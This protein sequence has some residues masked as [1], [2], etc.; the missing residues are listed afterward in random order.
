MRAASD[1]YFSV[2]YFQARQRF[3]EKAAAAGGI[4][5]ALPLDAKGPKGEDLSIDIARFGVPNASRILLHSSGL[6]GVEGFAGSAIQL[7]FIDD[8]PQIPPNC[9][10]VV[11]HILNPYGMAWL[12]RVNEEN[13][14]LNR[15]SMGD[16]P[17]S[18]A[19]AVY[20]QINSLLNPT[21][22]PS[23]DWFLLRTAGLIPRFGWSAMKQAVAGGQYDF[24]RGLFFGGK[25]HQTGLAAYHSFIE[26]S[27]GAAKRAIA[28]DIHT[29]LGRYGQD[30][31]LVD[32]E[33]LT[34]AREAFGS[35]V[36]ALQPETGS[37]YRVRG[38]LQF[39]IFRALAHADVMFIGQEFG[40]YN[41]IK[42]LHALRE[43][44]RWHHFGSGSPDHPVK[45]KIQEVFCPKG[46]RWRKAVLARG[47][48]LIRD[49]IGK[50]WQ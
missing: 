39:M 22:A 18:G 49:A 47:K 50:V 24:P 20:G 28:I 41:P 2:N 33:H 40:T 19:P 11:V 16:E 45:Q 46:E 1:S 37:A 12:R 25:R 3:R 9:G 30:I 38:G 32:S 21:S 42:V 29:G 13:V 17:Y 7:K 10:L 23:K 35:R 31:L 36:T 14:D 44:N 6:H 26:R 5:D 15:N 8:L 43:E 4:L 34:A 27:L 48:E